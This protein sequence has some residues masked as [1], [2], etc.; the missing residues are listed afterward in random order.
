MQAAIDPDHGFAFAS[1][2]VGL[3][4]GKIFG[5]REFL[6]DVFIVIEILDVRGR[7]DDHHPLAATLFGGAHVDHLHAV[8]FG[9]ELLPV[10]FR[11]FVI[12]HLVVVGDIEPE[13]FLGGG[14][15]GGRLSC[16]RRGRDDCQCKKECEV[17]GTISFHDAAFYMEAGEL[18]KKK[19]MDGEG[20]ATVVGSMM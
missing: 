1:E 11:L 16:K 10:G 7:G 6:G 15:F 5:A 8:G 2:G 18:S 14:D 19:G 9:G 13:K 12:H 20:V 4:V 17:T 3:I